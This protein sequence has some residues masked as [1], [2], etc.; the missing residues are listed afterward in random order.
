MNASILIEEPELEFGVGR[1]IDVRFGIMNRGA[2]GRGRPESPTSISLG[3]VGTTQSIEGILSW[4]A[5]C[6]TGV[7]AKQSK[8]PNLFP[9]FPGFGDDSCFGCGVTCD[10]RWQRA[11]RSSD[12]EQLASRRSADEF[13]EAAVDLFLDEI[14]AEREHPSKSHCMRRSISHVRTHGATSTRDITQ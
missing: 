3:V 7:D 1:H 9:R 13:V 10:S 8:Q 14:M 5:K 11:I 6:Q 12:I 4:L 2:W